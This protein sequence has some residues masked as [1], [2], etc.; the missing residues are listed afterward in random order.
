M[1]IGAEFPPPP[2][3]TTDEGW[4]AFTELLDK[5]A[6]VGE[7]RG[8]AK[9]RLGSHPDD[10]AQ[11][12]NM[13]ARVLWRPRQETPSPSELSSA[14]VNSA[15]MMQDG[16]WLEPENEPNHSNS[17][18]V[19]EGMTPGPYNTSLNTLI[20][21]AK[22]TSVQIAVSLILVSPGLMPESDVT[23]R[24]NTERWLS[25]SRAARDRCD[26]QGGHV[27]HTNG[28]NG[29]MYLPS[30]PN[31]VITEFG[32]SGNDTSQRAT[33]N[34]RVLREVMSRGAKAVIFFILP[35]PSGADEWGKY[36]LTVSAARSYREEH[37][38]WHAMNPPQEDNVSDQERAELREKML[39]VQR[40]LGS[41]VSG[42]L[43]AQLRAGG[44]RVKA[45]FDQQ[46]DA[47]NYLDS[48]GKV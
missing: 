13:G 14:L 10:V 30:E 33:L 12:R 22:S 20:D 24:S 5:Q 32:Y 45:A 15:Y 31:E 6:K 21:T 43:E 25:M 16:D 42:N 4:Q 27:Y 19:L 28:L 1:L 46:G 17:K 37:E 8:V 41:V 26:L 9:F 7:S 35:Y 36:F 44:D 47:I 38:R 18:W 48:L 29:I 39:E 3:R 34:N 2:H 11:A 40:I 23:S